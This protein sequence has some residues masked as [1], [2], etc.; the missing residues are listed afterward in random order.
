M[1]TKL[2]TRQ[3]RMQQWAA[4]IK[5]C[6]AS[7]MTVDADMPAEPDIEEVIVRR[8]RSK[9]KRDINLKDVEVEVISHIC[10]DEKLNEK[11]P[12][13]W[14]YFYIRTGYLPFTKVTS[15]RRLIIKY[16]NS[17]LTKR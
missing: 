1:D 3:I 6:R 2:A 4:T 12:K 9:G 7:G 11:F 17:R 15:V 8:K 5:D 16:K 13:G 14:R 10:T